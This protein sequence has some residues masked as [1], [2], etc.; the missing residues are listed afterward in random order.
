[1]PRFKCFNIGRCTKRRGTILGVLEF[2]ESKIL[3]SKCS[4]GVW[5]FATLLR[6]MVWEIVAF[7]QT[8]KTYLK[9][10]RKANK[11]WNFQ[12]SC[13]LH[14]LSDVHQ[15][16]TRTKKKEWQFSSFFLFFKV[17]NVNS[18]TWHLRRKRKDALVNRRP[19]K[20]RKNA[21]AAAS[22]AVTVFPQHPLHQQP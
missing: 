13:S 11:I 22:E 8:P 20:R 19:S 21:V 6:D 14:P 4:N 7:S 1:M 10:S 15:P 5:Y 17:Q 12:T 9:H 3:I 18:M 2:L 16:K